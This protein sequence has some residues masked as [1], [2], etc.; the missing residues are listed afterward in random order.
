VLGGMLAGAFL[1]IFFVPLFFVLIQRL[2]G[3]RK[4]PA[5][6]EERSSA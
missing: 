6:V 1:G 2:I 5:Q 3:G 4:Q